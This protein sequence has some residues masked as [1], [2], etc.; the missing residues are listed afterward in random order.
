MKK[1]LLVLSISALAS[2]ASATTVSC[3]PV[4]AGVGLQDNG[5]SV[6][7]A[8]GNGTAI[9][10]FSCPTISAGAGNVFTS[11]ALVASSDYTAQ[12]IGG[13]VGTVNVVMTFTAIGGP[14]GGST[15]SQT[16]A[17]DDTLGSNTHTPPTP[18]TIGSTIPGG[19]ST[20]A[21][22]VNAASVSNGQVDP[23]ASSGS[24][25][26]VYTVGPV[27]TTTPEPTTLGLMG[28]ALLGL[29]LLARRKK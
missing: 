13:P 17:G 3:T 1:Y 7:F 29:G 2:V 18:I 27:T 21:F 12:G 8:N 22:T 25:A 10:A 19:T 24:V 20:A 4:A 5:N 28:S 23:S 15:N 6:E 9:P 16:T 26:I 11:F 14:V